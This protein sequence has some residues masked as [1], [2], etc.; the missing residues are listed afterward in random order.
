MHFLFT[1]PRYHT[2]QRFAVKALLNAGHRVTFVALRK[3]HSEVYD[4][5]EPIV[6][7]EKRL[8]PWLPGG[9]R[10]C[11]PPSALWSLLRK[12]KP[13][14]VVAR[15]PYSAFGL[16]SIATARMTGAEAVFYS[17]N[18]M[19]RRLV[20][21]KTIVNSV[22]TRAANSRHITPVLGSPDHHPPA[23][24]ALRYVPF[25]M[26]P[27]TPPERK[28]WFRCGTVNIMTVGKFYRRKNHALFLE[29]IARLA[30]SHSVR[31]TII[32]ECTTDENR[33]ELTRV[34]EIHASLGLGDRVRI[35]TNLSYHDVQR[36]YAAHDLFV[37]PSSDEPAAVS[38]L[39]AMSHSLPVI[40]SDSNGTRC[41]IRHGENGY[42]FRTGDALDLEGR[43]E[44]IIAD[45]DRLV[46]MGERSHELVLSEHS[47][48][49]YVETMM[50]IARGVG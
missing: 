6:L 9:E 3:Q 11:P 39:E 35:K 25:V 33:R 20:W 34:R 23:F 30:E 47:P 17:Q 1:A 31:A 8:A 32:G 42:V 37:L 45:R 19:H 36:E 18:P 44:S 24:A 21:W 14:V 48:A 5:L 50:A 43:M 49:R 26:E 46:E 28:R 22:T 15:N 27:Q 40:C 16:M 41:Y 12:L 4:E 13:D 7:G 38:H 29:A 10:M 2:N